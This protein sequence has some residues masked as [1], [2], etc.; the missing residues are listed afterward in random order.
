MAQNKMRWMSVASSL[1]IS[2]KLRIPQIHWKWPN[3]VAHLARCVGPQH[4]WDR[5]LFGFVGTRRNWAE[6]LGWIICWS[7][8][9][10][11]CWIDM[12]WA[13][14]ST[15]NIQR[16]QWPHNQL[17]T[18]ILYD[19]S[20]GFFSVRFCTS[21][22]VYDMSPTL[23]LKKKPCLEAR[24][25]MNSQRYRDGG[26]STLIP[27]WRAILGVFFSKSVRYLSSLTCRWDML[28]TSAHEVLSQ[29]GWFSRLPMAQRS[30][31]RP[32]VFKTSCQQLEHIHVASLGTGNTFLGLQIS[33]LWYWLLPDC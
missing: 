28:L 15:N 33:H 16:I 21:T 3:Y 1:E 22:N 10:R 2:T 7:V 17:C 24:Q 29:N 13:H 19:S 8:A 23:S 30:D 12:F 14:V 32:K 18:L 6:T 26:S 9:Q 20:R 27:P 4:C 11:R 31:S 5:P 25:E